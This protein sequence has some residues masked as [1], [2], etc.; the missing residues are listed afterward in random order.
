MFQCED[1]KIVIH[2]EDLCWDCKHFISKKCVLMIALYE[3]SVF[4]PVNNLTFLHNCEFYEKQ[5]RTLKIAKAEKESKK[6]KK[7]SG[8]KKKSKSRKA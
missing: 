6:E 1:G 3:G 7:P 4:I 8:A 5:E 2:K